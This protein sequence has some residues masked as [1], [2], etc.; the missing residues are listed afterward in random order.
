METNELVL[1]DEKRKDVYLLDPRMFQVDEEFNVR[2]DY[3]DIPSLAQSISL[4]WSTNSVLGGYRGANGV[5]MIVDGFRRNR[6]IQ[7][8]IASGVINVD[9]WISDDDKE[10]E[11]PSIG[12]RVP[13]LLK[14]K[15]EWTMR[16]RLLDMYQSQDNKQLADGEK[17]ELFYRLQEQG[18]KVED[19]AKSI[20]K[21]PAHVSQMLSIAHAPEELRDAV[22]N[23]EMQTS[24]AL[25]I[26]SEAKK[27]SREHS[28]HKGVPANE[29][30][31]T[32]TREK[33]ERAILEAK[34]SGKT[35]VTKKQVSA[36]K[37]ESSIEK[38][39]PKG[40]LKILG[41]ILALAQSQGKTQMAVDFLEP[42]IE[43]LRDRK[44]TY[45]ELLTQ[46]EAIETAPTLTV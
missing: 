30:K 18:M 27:E 2:T 7:L 36:A 32:L 34:A 44:M 33:T 26:I 43:L 8:N 9:T 29:S 14:K 42:L 25:K 22:Y 46:W 19:I 31:N 17:C 40:M 23:G 35:V 12:F 39:A 11:K 1:L 41:E 20:G 5:I 13:V 10:K 6:A 45:A 37:K 28:K 38:E 21:S 16:Q 24:A 4:R 3:G 15:E